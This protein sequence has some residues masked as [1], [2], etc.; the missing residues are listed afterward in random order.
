[1]LR[2]FA[3]LSHDDCCPLLLQLLD[4][5]AIATLLQS[6][7]SLYHADVTN[8]TS[9]CDPVSISGASWRDL[10]LVYPWRVVD[11][12]Q[13]IAL[14]EPGCKIRALRPDSRFWRETFFR[15]CLRDTAFV[16][17]DPGSFELKAGF[18]SEEKPSVIIRT[19]VIA[20]TFS[21]SKPFNSS[22]PQDEWA[23]VIMTLLE[24]LG[25]HRLRASVCLVLNPFYEMKPR[26]IKPV[27]V[28]DLRKITAACIEDCGVRRMTLR[29]GPEMVVH[30]QNNGSPGLVLEVGSKFS[31]CVPVF[32]RHKSNPH[33]NSPSRASMS[34]TMPAQY[35]ASHF[36]MV[37]IGLNNASYRGEHLR[38][39]GRKGMV[40]VSI[41]G[42]ADLTAFMHQMISQHQNSAMACSFDEARQIKEA[43]CYVRAR[44]SKWMPAQGE[45]FLLQGKSRNLISGGSVTLSIER[46]RVPEALFNPSETFIKI[47]SSNTKSESNVDTDVQIQLPSEWSCTACTLINASESR[48]CTICG[49]IAPDSHISLLNAAAA[50]TR[51]TIITRQYFTGAEHQ[52]TRANKFHSLP[53]LVEIA[54]SKITISKTDSPPNLYCIGGGL[55]FRDLTRRLLRDINGTSHKRISTVNFVGN[56]AAWVGAATAGFGNP[57]DWISNEAWPL[58][59]ALQVVSRMQR[60]S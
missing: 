44:E 52:S 18:S 9:E 37:G 23:Q 30:S 55:A 32:C 27:P 25:V 60:K 15:V 5:K 2:I 14:F 54:L 26:I 38:G 35:S 40:P 58:P 45:D 22:S 43:E 7:K 48:I 53:E 1:M 42:G 29:W 11:A 57:S 59:A 46:F 31:F 51:E 21:S 8:S 33:A 16:V 20:S 12:S 47:L 17:I 50:A 13:Q 19:N 49:T 34:C 10:V 56:H 41:S 36:N 3:V 28:K 6:C 4:P 24:A 39:G